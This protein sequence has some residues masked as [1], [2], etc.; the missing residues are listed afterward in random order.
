MLRLKDIM[1]RDVVTLSP[2][3]TLR[4]AMELFVKRHV[5]GA[6][7]VS[8]GRVVGVLST[9]DILEFQS[10]ASEVREELAESKRAVGDADN[11]LA[12]LYLGESDEEEDEGFTAFL[13]LLEDK[14]WDTLE[15]H[16]VSEI[17]TQAIFSL[18]PT[19][20]VTDAAEYMR[21]A[22]VHRILVMDEDILVGIVTTSDL[23]AAV[24]DR[25][26]V[27]TRYVFE[28]AGRTVVGR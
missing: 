14:Q 13:P 3:M 22:E 19:A 2:T 16:M 12:E 8:R 27:K 7:V 18:P 17:M 5:S 15:E 21:Q 4:E 6:P 28:R 1:T 20:L 25:R 26:L 24:A 9:T 11:V 23:T 10:V